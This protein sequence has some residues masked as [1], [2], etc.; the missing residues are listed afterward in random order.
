MSD[1][2]AISRASERLV[3][4]SVGGEAQ[5]I[6]PDVRVVEHGETAGRPVVGAGA[7]VTVAEPLVVRRASERARERFIEIIEGLRDGDRKAT[8]ALFAKLEQQ[9]TTDFVLLRRDLETL[10]STTDE[11]I[12]DART[13]LYQLASIQ[14]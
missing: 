2:S 1:R 4:E 9:Y 12:E 3:V 10:A 8:E 13:K 7:G 6:Y 11:E 5:S 14:K